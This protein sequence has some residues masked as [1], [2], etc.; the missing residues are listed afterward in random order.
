MLVTEMVTLRFLWDNHVMWTEV[1]TGFA[2]P[3]A[4][5][6]WRSHFFKKNNTELKIKMKKF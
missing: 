3:E 1:N 6:L 5:T 4:Y 2:V